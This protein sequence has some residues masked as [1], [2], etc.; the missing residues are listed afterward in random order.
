MISMY[1]LQFRT[2]QPSFTQNHRI[3][4]IRA[5]GLSTRYPSCDGRPKPQLHDSI[6]IIHIILPCW[7][8]Q[9]LA[10][11]RALIPASCFCRHITT[12]NNTDRSSLVT[13]CQPQIIMPLYN[14]TSYVLRLRSDIGGTSSVDENVIGNFAIPGH[15]CC[16]LWSM[17]N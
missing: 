6:Q 5:L 13:H 8:E 12:D 11:F 17:W 9:S 1:M 2:H 4:L 14:W 7:N 16:I 3:T 15:K 10:V